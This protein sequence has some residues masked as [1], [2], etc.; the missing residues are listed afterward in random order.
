MDQRTAR[1]LT[2]RRGRLPTSRCSSQAKSIDD[3][4]DV[5]L[6]GGTALDPGLFRPIRPR[7]R[8]YPRDLQR[9]KNAAALPSL[10]AL[11]FSRS[12][13]S[14]AKSECLFLS[15]TDIASS[16][17]ISSHVYGS[18]EVSSTKTSRQSVRPQGSCLHRR[19]AHFCPLRK[20]KILCGGYKATTTIEEAQMP[21]PTIGSHFRRLRA[22]L[23]QVNGRTTLPAHLDSVALAV[24]ILRIGS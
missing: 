12:V 18:F 15:C 22:V 9:A 1:I 2:S 17:N 13:P 6:T 23:P 19:T 4:W 11:L 16:A 3:I 7:L 21:V 10:T 14:L 8:W 20:P 24:K 5:L